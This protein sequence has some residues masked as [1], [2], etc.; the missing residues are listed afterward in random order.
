MGTAGEDAGR[1]TVP[2]VGLRSPAAAAAR[3]TATAAGGPAES[4]SGRHMRIGTACCNARFT[5]QR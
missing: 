5:L 3:A 1:A 4:C 2:V